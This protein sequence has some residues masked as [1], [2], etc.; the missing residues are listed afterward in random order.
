MLPQVLINIVCFQFTAVAESCDDDVTSALQMHAQAVRQGVADVSASQVDRVFQ[1]IRDTASDAEFICLSAHAG[2]EAPF[3][4]TFTPA[5]GRKVSVD[6]GHAA[7][8]SGEYCVQSSLVS[9][10]QRAM[11]DGQAGSFEA[12]VADKNTEGSTGGKKKRS[13]TTTTTTSSKNSSCTEDCCGGASEYCKV[14][15]HDFAE[16]LCRER[17][18]P[19]GPSTWDDDRMEKFMRNKYMW[20]MPFQGPNA[21]GPSFLQGCTGIAQVD[22][23]CSSDCKMTCDEAL[24]GFHMEMISNIGNPTGF[25][26]RPAYPLCCPDYCPRGNTTSP[27]EVQESQAEVYSAVFKLEDPCTGDH[28]KSRCAG[29]VR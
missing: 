6:V 2:E 3:P 26:S 12:V 7:S 27:A 14:R 24:Q 11:V 1:A 28:I 8:E 10:M 19:S 16:I 22:S 17:N 21:N 4:G 5:S 15:V 20:G 23:V 29:A 9:L 13:T 18:V 25:D